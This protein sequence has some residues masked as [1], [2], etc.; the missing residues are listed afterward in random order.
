[1]ANETFDVLIK[2]VTEMV[3]GGGAEKTLQSIEGME[4]SLA[5]GNE[6][7]KNQNK[8]LDGW[9]K[10]LKELNIELQNVRKGG[11]AYKQIKREI[12]E[13]K[14][15][16]L[17]GTEVIK[18]TKEA[19][20][21]LAQ[22]IR[23]AGEAE[24]KRTTTTRQ[25][26]EVMTRMASTINGISN[27]LVV[28]GTAVAGGIFKS[29]KDF[30]GN[31]EESSQ[32]TREWKKETESLANSYQRVG[33]VAAAEVLPFMK[34]ASS[35]AGKI[36]S[37]VEANPDI[38]GGALKVGMIAL[39]VG[40]IG[41]AVAGGIKLV[42][43]VTMIAASATQLL[44]SSQNMLAAG[45][46]EL[47]SGI[48][49]TT[50]G[51]VLIPALVV[52]AAVFSGILVG[53][54][55]YEGIAKNSGGKLPDL[56]TL[57]TQSAMI[58]KAKIDEL[59]K[60]FMDTGEEAQGLTDDMKSL[61]ESFTEMR[62]K[63]K[64]EEGRYQAEREKIISDGNSAIKAQAVSHG[65]RIR[66]ITERAESE[67]A[68]IIENYA[69]QAAADAAQY[70]A[71]RAAIIRD[72]G[73]EIQRIEQD[74]LEKLR[75][76]EQDHN[77]RMDDLAANRDALGLVLEQRKFEQD[78]AELD[79]QTNQE[80]ARR[81]QDMA[82]RLQDLAA[83]FAAERAQKYAQY[84]Q[85]LKENEAKKL[86]ELEQERIEHQEKLKRIIKD[87]A[88]KLRELDIEHRE[89][90]T[91]IRQ[92]FLAKVRDLDASLLGEQQKRRQYQQLMMQDLEKFLADYRSKSLGAAGTGTVGRAAGGYTH[93][94]LVQTHGVEF[95][96]NPF[97]TRALE[98]LIGGRL[99]QQNLVAAVAGGGGSVV[100]NDQRRFSG[101]YTK[102]MRRENHKDTIGILKEVFKK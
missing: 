28:G 99:N 95:V 67:R 11:A 64:Q 78:K 23:A 87:R 69:R 52:L 2:F 3:G 35:I 66:A 32:L 75:Q 88:D 39:A 96:T 31:A 47:A 98:R 46:M 68:R 5:A 93:G 90:M 83:N 71:D 60:S 82:M 13:A 15:V 62:E 40:T 48:F 6:L 57:G 25:S 33:A 56:E 101:E 86:Q 84:Q 9:K 29:A 63:E 55:A 24:K 79:R 41:K 94:E 58:L 37:I 77:E 27:T 85:D 20:D 80:I 16:I 49:A 21:K 10:K 36:A 19:N 73:V 22:S 51:A 89:E 38:V 1:M 92:A 72:G 65:A 100:W 59:K 70:E 74:R 76:M 14:D 45:G 7:L 34:E 4:K 8:E 61:S 17:Q 30:I 54:M 102:S 43:D 91:R 26:V 42:A 12:A 44:A 53:L 18:E 50:V 81:R 97:T